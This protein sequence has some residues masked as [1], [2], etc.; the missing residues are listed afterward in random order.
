M[1]A[2][3]IPLNLGAAERYAWTSAE[4]YASLASYRD[5]VEAFPTG[6][7][8]AEAKQHVAEAYDRAIAQYQA[9]A[10]TTSDGAKAIVA[11]LQALQASGA[12]A[13]DVKYE[14]A[15]DFSAVRQFPEKGII[16]AEPAFTSAENK[17]REHAITQALRDAFGNVV[18]Y[19][20]IDFDDGGYRYSYDSVNRRQRERKASPVT[21]TIK[22]RVGPSG[23]IY[24][25]TTGTS[26]KFYGI[27]FD[28]EL[29]IVDA[30]AGKLYQTQLSSAPA[31]NIRY[32]TTGYVQSDILPY[33]KMA[34]SAFSEFGR[35]LAGDFGVA[36]PKPAEA[37]FGNG[38][39]S[40]RGSVPGAYSP[41]VQK[42]LDDLAKSGKMSPEVRKMLL[43]AQK[44][45]RS[46]TN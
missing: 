32:T 44:R 20:V 8:V 26:R 24:E 15:I 31:K 13:V 3:A 39:P 42:A 34:E 37:D 46:G 5:Y 10:G 36:V 21:F 2:A 14:S 33:T 4:R 45:Q 25:S 23:T 28:W 40:S 41:E 11:V 22:Y 30:K 7:H 16:D 12:R 19:D 18:G 17:S 9:K 43:D 38:Y 35:K 1:F 6:K 27:L 29:A